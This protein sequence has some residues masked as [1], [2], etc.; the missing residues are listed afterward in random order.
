M[1]Y[2]TLCISN[3]YISYWHHG[4]VLYFTLCDGQVLC[5]TLIPWISAVFS[6]RHGKCWFLHSHH[7]QGLYSTF[8]SWGSVMFRIESWAS[9][10]F[11]ID[12]MGKCHISK[13]TSCTGGRFSIDIMGKW[14]FLHEHH[15]QVLYSKWTSWARAI[16]HNDILP[17]AILHSDI[18]GTC[19]TT[20]Y[21]WASGTSQ[22]DIMIKCSIAHCDKDK[23]HKSR[24]HRGQVLYVAFCMAMSCILRW[25][26]GQVIDSHCVTGKCYFLN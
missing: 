1:L 3:C 17:S 22:N 15:G 9:A 20:H 10:I 8:T 18:M 14:Y 23:F 16:F 4:K 24:W 13:L 21:A 12:I 5:F 7:G 25:Y 19:Y 6:V 11:R 26:H 2:F